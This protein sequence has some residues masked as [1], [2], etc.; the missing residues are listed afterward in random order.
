MDQ[1]LPHGPLGVHTAFEPETKTVEAPGCC[2]TNQRT[3]HPAVHQLAGPSK[4]RVIVIAGQEPD[5]VICWNVFP[6]PAAFPNNRKPVA[7]AEFQGRG[8]TTVCQVSF[9]HGFA[10]TDHLE[11]ETDP[12]G[13]SKSLRL[14]FMRFR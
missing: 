14:A 2:P 11:S 7:C 1:R 12:S 13:V 4:T 5:A 3:E 9:S 6:V 10:I 8:A